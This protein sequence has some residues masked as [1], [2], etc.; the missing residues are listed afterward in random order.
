MS[1]AFPPV[2]IHTAHTLYISLLCTIPLVLLYKNGASYHLFKPPF[3]ST[4]YN[5]ISLTSVSKTLFP[6]KEIQLYVPNVPVCFP[7]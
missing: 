7:L 4:P 2:D 5:P 1:P 6:L 3:L